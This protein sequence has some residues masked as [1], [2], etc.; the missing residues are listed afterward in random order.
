MGDPPLLDGAK[1]SKS[2]EVS[3]REESL[4]IMVGANGAFVAI[5]CIS[6]LYGPTPSTFYTA[7]LNL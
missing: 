5:S 4:A 3:V 6:R 7:T 2:I 1:N